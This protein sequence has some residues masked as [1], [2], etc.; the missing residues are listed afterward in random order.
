M[1]KNE[2]KLTVARFSTC[3]NNSVRA[4][5]NGGAGLSLALILVSSYW[6]TV[7]IRVLTGPHRSQA[8]VSHF[9]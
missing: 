4:Q 9:F 2:T 8:V 1:G 7:D 5:V 3:K 6:C